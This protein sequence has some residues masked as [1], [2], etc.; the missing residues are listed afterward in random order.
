MQWAAALAVALSAS[1]AVLAGGGGNASADTASVFLRAW[2]L[3]PAAGNAPE[4]TLRGY[5]S[6][7]IAATAAGFTGFRLQGARPLRPALQLRPLLRMHTCTAPGLVQ[8][9]SRDPGSLEAPA[10]RT[11]GWCLQAVAGLMGGRCAAAGDLERAAEEASGCAG[12]AAADM[13][14]LTA[15]LAGLPRS[16]A[17]A[18]L[19]AFVRAQYS[20]LLQAK[21]WT[22]GITSLPFFNSM[23]CWASMKKNLLVILQ[24]A[25]DPDDLL[26]VEHMVM[27]VASMV[28]AVYQSDPQAAGETGWGWAA[29]LEAL[30][31]AAVA[32][33]AGFEVDVLP[34]LIGCGTSG[35]N[36]AMLQVCLNTLLLIAYQRGILPAKCRNWPYTIEL[37][38]ITHPRVQSHLQIAKMLQEA[39]AVH[40]ARR[41][42]E[43]LG[44]AS[45]QLAARERDA[46]LALSS[47][48]EQ[49]RQCN[50]HAT[51]FF[52]L[53]KI[54]NRI[55]GQH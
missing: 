17:Q 27:G 23:H 9:L 12:T 2:R 44:L 1:D 48:A 51:C 25:S 52:L 34:V 36:A 18:A 46:K 31:E 30:V 47:T 29:S 32:A 42:L 7:Q 40:H 4:D 10:W 41:E 37:L 50:L 33:K 5:A 19:T 3:A 55:F 13:A 43:A 6:L 11:I 14:A 8:A 49:A 20:A 21:V 15:C 54:Q 28:A 45:E 39:G 35:P 22:I 26:E 16:E 53:W 24:A 38:I